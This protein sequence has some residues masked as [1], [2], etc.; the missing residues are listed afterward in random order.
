MRPGTKIAVAVILATLAIHFGPHDGP[1]PTPDKPGKG[2]VV[3]IVEETAERAKLPQ[4][5]LNILT[6]DKVRDY[7][8]EHCA[9]DTE[10]HP[11]WRILDDDAPGDNLP[12]PLRDALAKPRD[13][14]PWIGISNG[15]KGSA[16]ALP[17]DVDATLTLLK[18]YGGA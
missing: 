2:L 15:R 7:L 11:L 4:P 14:V 9:K 18:K 6:S 17:A 3:L 8:D 1:A 13:S 10:G 5:Q 12:K 16:G